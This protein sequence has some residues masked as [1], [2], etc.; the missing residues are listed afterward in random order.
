[1]PHSGY[2]SSDD[3]ILF[4]AL[5]PNVKAEFQC[6]IVYELYTVKYLTFDLSPGSFHLLVTIRLGVQQPG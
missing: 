5:I 2:C 6:F 4:D 3:D 1:M